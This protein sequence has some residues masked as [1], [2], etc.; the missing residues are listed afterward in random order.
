[1]ESEGVIIR[2]PTSP[3]AAPIV[4]V[5]KQDSDVVRMC[6]DFSMTFNACA[7]VITYPI[8]KIED[9]HTALRGCKVFSTLDMSQAYHQCLL[10]RIPKS[11]LQ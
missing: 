9:L 8:P 2:V 5:A 3:C 7:E 1:M 4:P 11:I 10:P 6:G